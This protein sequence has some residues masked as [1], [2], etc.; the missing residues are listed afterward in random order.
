M[1]STIPR[2]Y[3]IIVK[4]DE[5]LGK[6]LSALGVPSDKAA[7]MRIIQNNTVHMAHMAIFASQ[8]VNGVAQLHTEIL[9]ND[10][11]KD[12]YNIYPN[13]FQNKTN[14]ITQRRWLALCNPELSD[15]L[16]ELLGNESWKTDLSQ[17]KKL[18]KFVSDDKIMERVAQIK[19][20]N[21]K[22]LAAYIQKK[23]GIYVDPN[24]CFDIQIKRLHE[25]KRQFLNILAI[26][27]LYYE[28]IEGSLTDFTP[29]TFIFGAKLVKKR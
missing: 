5:A 17:L 24:T 13:R 8:Y 15:L 22:R 12:W 16:T 29:K 10:V 4:I 26:L 28:I 3:D 9:K 21:H 25:Y 7:S 6:E 11:L 1:I 23:D 19:M 18:E 27:E 14:G 2:V 20:N